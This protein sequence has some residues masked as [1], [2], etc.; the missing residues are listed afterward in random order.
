V[1]VSLG[2]V[3]L[4]SSADHTRM[5]GWNV[6]V[7]FTTCADLGDDPFDMAGWTNADNRA[8]SA[9]RP[10]RLPRPKGKT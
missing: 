2:R 9:L 8:A 6:G 5:V 10:T 4:V 7:A 1:D 3:R